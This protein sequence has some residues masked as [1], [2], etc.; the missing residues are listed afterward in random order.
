MMTIQEDRYSSAGALFVSRLQ[1]WYS[2]VVILFIRKLRTKNNVKVPI[3][4]HVY[5][6]LEQFLIDYVHDLLREGTQKFCRQLPQGLMALLP[7]G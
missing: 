7:S 5:A 1:N 2:L 3:L 4:I 6:V